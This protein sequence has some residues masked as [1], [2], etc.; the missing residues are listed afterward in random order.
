[1]EEFYNKLSKEELITVVINLQNRLSDKDKEIEILR[2]KK[3][4]PQPINIKVTPIETFLDK[5]PRRREIHHILSNSS[6]YKLSEAEVKFLKSI[7]DK[8]GL[9]PKQTQ[10]LNSIKKRN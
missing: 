3:D 2:A 1:M 10:W 8:V 5:N 9:S 4:A 6:M 7:V